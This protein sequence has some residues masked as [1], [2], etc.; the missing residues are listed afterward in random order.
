MSEAVRIRKNSLFS[1]LSTSSRL[2]ANVVVF[3]IIGSYYG[4]NV[5]G[6]F[7]TANSF[8]LTF[9]LFANFGFDVLLT[10]EIAKNRKKASAIFQSYFSLKIF[11]AIFAV[12]AMWLVSL[13]HH[14]STTSRLL[15]FIFSFYVILTALTT[16]I[17]ALFE[18]L[19]RFEFETKV[20][21]IVNISLLFFVLFLLLIKVNIIYI[22][23]AFVATRLLGLIYAVFYSF[24]V[25]P[26][27]KYN[28][29]FK[30]FHK[31]KNQV[32]IFGLQLIFGNLFFQLDTLLLAFWKGDLTVGI[33]QATIKL[34]ALPLVIPDILINTLMPTLSR[35]NIENEVLWTRL[36]GLL[37]KTLTIIIL[38]ISIVL[39]VYPDYVINLVYHSGKFDET[40]PILKIFALILFIRFSV[41]SYALMLTTSH[42][43]KERMLVVILGTLLNLILNAF[44]IPLYGAHGAAFVSLITNFLVGVGYIIFTLPLFSKWVTNLS[45]F[46]PIIIAIIITFILLAIKKFEPIIMIPVI[47]V[48]CYFLFIKF[49]YN[50]EERNL[51][52]KKGIEFPSFFTKQKMN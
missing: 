35:L 4:P 12:I 30:E 13:L 46:A 51:V 27:I 47:F 31:I 49:S 22:A 29:S 24:K 21:F 26:D 48:I 11:F 23:I 18:G 17:H 14:F 52:F 2:I 19:E 33:Y 45:Y 9:V 32:V 1:F 50:K 40:I 16:F 7:T 5:F 41:E 43:Q 28:L 25:L 36:G 39:F 34:I 10:T 42:K 6:Q 15:I 44:L 3:L 20:S 8:A 38:P 37:N